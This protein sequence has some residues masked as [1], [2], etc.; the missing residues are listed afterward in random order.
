MNKEQMIDLDNLTAS[1]RLELIGYIWN[2][3]TPE[4]ESIPVSA[5]LA[6]ELD[7]RA[8]AFDAD[9]NAAS[10]WESVRRRIQQHSE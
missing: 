8:A 7:R 9:P 1:D 2:S 10:S 4:P 3:L 6:A 5:E